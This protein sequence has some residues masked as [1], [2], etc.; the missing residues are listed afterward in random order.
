MDFAEDI[1][2]E[3]LLEHYR[4]PQNYGKIENADVNYRDFNPVCGDEIEVFAKVKNSAIKDVKFTGKGC[5]ISQASA[6]ILTEQIKGKSLEEFKKMSNEK[7][8]GLLPVKVSHLRIKCA[9]LALKA[10]QKGLLIYEGKNK[11]ES[12]LTNVRGFHFKRK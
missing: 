3:E 2:R 8:L 1:Y 12:I 9:L 6:S 10:V 7:M 11:N 5:A 4:N